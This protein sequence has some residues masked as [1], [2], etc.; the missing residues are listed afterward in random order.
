MIS[1]NRLAQFWEGFGG[2]VSYYQRVDLEA[3]MKFESS[4]P[5]F[6]ENETFLVSGARCNVLRYQ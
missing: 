2:H 6:K 1:E 3:L 4:W 5:L